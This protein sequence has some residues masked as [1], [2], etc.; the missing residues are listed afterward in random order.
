[1]NI[2]SIRPKN[3]SDFKGQKEAIEYLKLRVENAIKNETQLP[4]SLLLGPG[5][6][7]KTSLAFII[8]SELGVECHEI[9]C[10]Q[11]DKF[12][13]IASILDNIE[14]GDVV[15]FDE[16]HQLPKSEQATLYN[17]LE[18]FR[19][20]KSVGRGK[21][22]RVETEYLPQFTA[23]A[24]TT[25]E[26]RLNV[27]LSRR[28]PNK[29]RL[30]PYSAEEISDMLNSA[31]L[32]IYSEL[33][34]PEV[35]TTIGKVSNNSAYTAYSL[36]QSYYEI[37]DVDGG[38]DP[39]AI[40]QRTLRLNQIDPLLGLNVLHRKY[41]SILGRNSDKLYSA[42]TI[43]TQMRERIENIKTNIE[44]VLVTPIDFMGQCEPFVE[45]KPKGR[46]IT[47]LGNFYLDFCRKLQKEQNWFG[48]ERL[49]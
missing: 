42:E 33:I 38:N 1:M 17:V 22:K 45:I 41:L 35:A 31:S 11:I 10:Q 26:D 19:Y 12:D 6:V 46:Q 25:H 14:E 15:F 7:G 20:Q 18:D 23:I 49:S 3:F 47:K 39:R 30:V 34:H 44:P 32:R 13:E 9:A 37:K 24:A 4:H 27:S 36:M 43:A 8:A 29:V 48:S 2:D 21:D 28:F 16:I 40:L 5:G